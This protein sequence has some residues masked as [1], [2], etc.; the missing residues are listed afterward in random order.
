MTVTAR[1]FGNSGETSAQML[2]RIDSLLYHDT[3][4]VAGIF[5]FPNDPTNSISQATTQANLQAM[6]KAL[7]HGAIGAGYGNGAT[8][9]SQTNLPATGEMGQ[10]YVV[11]ADTSTS[12]GVT[13]W[14]A[15]H[16]ATITGSL[17]GSPQ[18][19]WEY[20]YPLAG[21]AGWGRVATAA[22]APTVVPRIFVVGQGY[23]NWSTGGDTPTTPYATYTGIRAAAAAA[24]TA[25]TTGGAAGSV[26]F[27]DLYAYQ[28]ARIT[29][30][31]DPDASTAGFSAATSWHV[32]DADIHHNA[33][34][35]L[36]VARAVAE[37]LL[38]QWI[39]AA[40]GKTLSVI[41]DS[42]TDYSPGKG[43]DGFRTWVPVLKQLIGT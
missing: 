41:G 2:A 42:Q 32:A 38:S 11:L 40:Q 5:G 23:L 3:P 27:I 35:H 31:T 33:Y 18:A 30:T 8:I 21:E 39:A 17:S 1:A 7:K 34:G 14:H 15:S 4:A 43:V 13:G 29:A 6:I 24:V 16:A 22:T 28:K 20:R 26:V 25:E 12:G 36:L 9:A 10:R 37:N 19:V